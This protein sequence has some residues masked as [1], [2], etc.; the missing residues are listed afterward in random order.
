MAKENPGHTLQ[1]T[2]LVNEVCLRLVDVHEVSWQ[3][4]AHPLRAGN[5]SL[6][7]YWT[8]DSPK[9]DTPHVEG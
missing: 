9:V 7:A 8:L 3:D 5:K 1:T 2:A 6:S 4:R